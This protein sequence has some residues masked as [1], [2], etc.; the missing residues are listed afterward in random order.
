MAISHLF[1]ALEALSLLRRP[2]PRSLPK[3]SAK[4]RRR[5]LLCVMSIVIL[6]VANTLRHSFSNH[7][8][9]NIEQTQILKI[10]TRISP[11]TYYEGADGPGGFEYKLLSL[12][13]NEI[14]QQLQ[15]ETTATLNALFEK[16]SSEQVDF[17]SAALTPTSQRQQHYNF[18]EPYLRDQ[19]IVVYR[20]GKLR[21][22]NY[23]DLR[24]KEVVVVADSSHSQQL[25]EVQQSYPDL[26]WRELAN[27]DFVDLLSRVENGDVDYTI[28]DSTEFMLHQGTFPHVKRAFDFGEAQSVSWMFT[29]TANADQLRIAANQ[30]IQKIKTNGI[31]AKLEERYFGQSSHIDQVAAN[32]FSKNIDTRLTHYIDDIKQAANETGIDWQLLAAMSYQESGW[33]PLATSP[34]GV[35]GMMMLTL[36]TAKEIGVD[37]RLDIEQS[38][39]GGAKYYLYLKKRLPEAILEPDRSW[40]ALAAYNVGYGHLQDA[41]ILTR[42]RGKDANSWV[43]VKQTLPLLTEPAWYKKTRYGYARGYE[44]VH[45]VQQIRHY[46]NVLA[47]NDLATEL[48]AENDDVDLLFAELEINDQHQYRWPS[49]AEPH[50][51]NTSIQPIAATTKAALADA[52]S[53]LSAEPKPL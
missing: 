10:V 2:G 48:I 16:V 13:A 50:N 4:M 49:D 1:N 26:Q 22:R 9:T 52:S 30:F 44:P 17:A 43:H 3:I 5:A 37:D 23:S 38:L 47:W 20:V 24:G 45:Y 15:L 35:R 21:P 36:P 27:V 14:G 8:D 51:T 39:L 32:E 42:K 34:T 53:L 46:R 29:K 19:P 28:I 41:R 6:L 25:R 33:D 40:F 12:F 18:S 7:N 31:L 11:N